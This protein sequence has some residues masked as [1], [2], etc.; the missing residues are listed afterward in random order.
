MKCGPIDVLNEVQRI[1]DGSYSREGEPELSEPFFYCRDD[2]LGVDAE[3]KRGD[4]PS[5][6]DGRGARRAG[7]SCRFQELRPVL[8][9][10][11][12]AKEK[13]LVRVGTS[14]GGKVIGWRP[15]FLFLA[16]GNT[17]G[18]NRMKALRPPYT[19]CK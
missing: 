16:M 8:N 7:C 13:R 19:D 5:A 4:E 1:V 17:A 3:F 10:N 6:A 9:N 15:G 18:S 2:V 14:E 11:G 12:W